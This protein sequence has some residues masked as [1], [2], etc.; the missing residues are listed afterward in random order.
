MTSSTTLL[1]MNRRAL[2]CA[3]GSGVLA[4]CNNVDNVEVPIDAQATIPAATILDELIGPLTFFGLENIDLTNELDNQ[5][6]TKDDVDSVHMKS[7]SLI[8]T[9]PAGQTFDFMQ[10]ISFT[11]STEGKPEALVAKLDPVPKGQTTIEL[12]P[13]A[14]L[15][16]AP[17]VVAPRMTMTTSVKGTRPMQETTVIAELVFD[18]DVNVSGCA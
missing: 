13:E 1:T 7:F 11:V 17:Y 12:V 2:L 16:L 6:V 10:S 9:A 18:I 5:G 4:S 8:I 14:T 15:D 3:L